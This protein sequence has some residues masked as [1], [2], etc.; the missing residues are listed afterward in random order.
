MS[1]ASIALVCRLGGESNSRLEVLA[2]CSDKAFGEEEMRSL[3]HKCITKVRDG[4]ILHLDKHEDK[5]IVSYVFGLARE[6]RRGDLVSL[7]LVLPKKENPQL[8]TPLVEEI[9]RILEEQENLTP[10]F[11]VRNLQTI[12]DGLSQIRDIELGGTLVEIERI[13]QDTKDKLTDFW[14]AL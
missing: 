14:E 10:F 3:A 12:Y 6:G 1:S 7:A 13:H 5:K 8:Y 2:S 11:L 4:G 9:A